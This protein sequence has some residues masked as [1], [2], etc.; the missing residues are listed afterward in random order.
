MYLMLNDLFFTHQF[1]FS[2][3]DKVF[4]VEFDHKLCRASF[5]VTAMFVRKFS[6]PIALLS[7]EKPQPNPHF[8]STYHNFIGEPLRLA[9]EITI[10]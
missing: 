4:S 7:S 5:V 6:L 1:E 10:G 9:N 2:C 3:P 8:R